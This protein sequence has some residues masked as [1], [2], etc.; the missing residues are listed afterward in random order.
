LD[1]I[2]KSKTRPAW[3]L[4]FLPESANCAKLKKTLQ[5]SQR[6]YFAGK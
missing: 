6:E 5:K 2:E 1:A 3:T 4:A